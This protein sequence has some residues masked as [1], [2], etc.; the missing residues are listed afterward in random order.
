M[1]K[2]LAVIVALAASVARAEEPTAPDLRPVFVDTAA[3]LEMAVSRDP[4]LW[5]RASMLRSRERTATTMLVVTALGGMAVAAA[6]MMNDAE[7]RLIVPGAVSTLV[8]AIWAQSFQPEEWEYA[9]VV[10]AW[11]AAHPD[12]P[13]TR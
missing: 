9:A 7:P 10:D 4:A 12:A 13:L 2:R 11:N 3:D 6:G 1:A 5:A 8:G